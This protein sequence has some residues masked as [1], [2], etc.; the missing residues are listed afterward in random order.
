MLASRLEKKKREKWKSDGEPTWTH[1][2][3]K[4]QTSKKKSKR[5]TPCS[6]PASVSA[7]PGSLSNPS[8]PSANANNEQG[9]KIIKNSMM[10]AL[11]AATTAA[12]IE[13]ANVEKEKP[14]TAVGIPPSAGPFFPPEA[15]IKT[16]S[17]HCDAR[18]WQTTK[19]ENAGR[20]RRESRQKKSTLKSGSS[21]EV[22]CFPVKHR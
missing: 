4:E 20:G 18:R 15:Q 8:S 21:L 7:R 13:V 12:T 11:S 2:T 10:R 17:R 1:K 19:K 5:P 16:R 6:R 3:P 14:P 22:S 9:Q